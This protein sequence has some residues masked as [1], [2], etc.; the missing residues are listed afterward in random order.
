M[1]WTNYTFCTCKW[2]QNICMNDK[3]YDLIQ[4]SAYKVI[5][6][7]PNYFICHTDHQTRDLL[8][9]HVICM[10]K[11]KFL[12]GTVKNRVTVTYFFSLSEHYLLTQLTCSIIFNLSN[13]AVQVRD[14]APAIPPATKWR[15]HIPV[16]FSF[17]VNSGGQVMSS[18]MSI[19]YI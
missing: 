16:A 1:C 2:I 3:W 17:L 15:H 13:G 6:K 7:I 11:P 10:C 5:H 9:I 18:P 19:I 8:S 4:Y 14:T 12:T